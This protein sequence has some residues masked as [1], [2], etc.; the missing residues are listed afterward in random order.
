MSKPPTLF[1]VT[2]IETTLKR[3]I[4]FD[5]AWKI[6]DRRGNIYG[7]GSF[8]IRKAFYLDVPFFKEKLGHYFDDAYS[9]FIKPAEILDVRSLYNSQIRELQSREHRVICAAYNSAFD[10]KYLPETLITL[11]DGVYSRWL[12]QKTELLDIWDFW[13]MSV[14]KIYAK[15]APASDSGKY[16]AT[17]AEAAYKFEFCKAEFE[18]RHIAWS[19][20][21]IESDLL[22]K[23][24]LRKK[25]MPVVNSPA[26]LA[27]S[28]W[29]KINTRLGITGKE[30]LPQAVGA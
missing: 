26:E 10:F 27:G 29:K 19:D 5:I 20:V 17:S 16:V 9:Q 6:I 18:E 13:G 3:R 4:A 8:V 2:D 21:L 28:V 25:K 23:T 14:P 1:V 11:T 15:C 12:E 24:L 7:S 30:L 22:Q